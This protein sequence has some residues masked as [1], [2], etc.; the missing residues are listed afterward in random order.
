[1]QRLLVPPRPCSE[2]RDL[3]AMVENTLPAVE[4]LAV[5]DKCTP[6]LEKL[7]HGKVRRTSTSLVED[8][9]VLADQ[10]PEIRSLDGRLRI[11]R[12]ER[13]PNAGDPPRVPSDYDPYQTDDGLLVEA[14]SGKDTDGA[15]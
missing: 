13:H 7:A 8:K 15:E 4:P 1:L 9:V 12:R 5:T 11:A 3:D 14:A 6:V 2:G 10:V